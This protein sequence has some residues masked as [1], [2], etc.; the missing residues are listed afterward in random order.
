MQRMEGCGVLRRIAALSVVAMVTFASPVLAQQG[1]LAREIEGT[2]SLVSNYNE[3][4]GKRTE[5]FGT[6]PRG[7][8]IL[9]AGG[10]FAIMM[11]KESLPAFAA[12]NRV[13]GTAPE[14][15]AVVQGSVAYFGTYAVQSEKDKTV[16]LRI[17][18]STFPN[19]VGQE[20]KRVMSVTGDQLNLTNP[21]AAVGGT[22]YV[23]F[24]R[25]R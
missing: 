15:Q 6:N 13:Q 5:P 11:M 25:A 23:V 1:N 14:N 22:N 10:R 24:K 2:W 8:M 4:D 20:Q 19:W 17:E 16:T 9:T 18:G 7:I 3:Q 12:N 21:S